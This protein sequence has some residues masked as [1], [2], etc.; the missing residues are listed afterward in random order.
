MRAA[1]CRARCGLLT[2]ETFADLP[3]QPACFFFCSARFSLHQ[4]RFFPVQTIEAA[5]AAGITTPL[6]VLSATRNTLYAEQR[7]RPRRHTAADW[8][9]RRV[10][11]HE[12][13]LLTVRLPQ[14]RMTH[15]NHWP[16]RDA[17][18]LPR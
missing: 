11:G 12:I 3:R 14:A 5:G 13:L 18:M 15:A 4:L 6:T 2:S 7:A 17:S 10:G 1:C 9:A 8:L 16:R